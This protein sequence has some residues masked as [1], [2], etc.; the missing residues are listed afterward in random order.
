MKKTIILPLFFFLTSCVHET[1]NKNTPPPL[2]ATKIQYPC[3]TFY[4]SSTLVT[5][6]YSRKMVLSYKVQV[7][8]KKGFLDCEKL[9]KEDLNKVC[10]TGQY[11]GIDLQFVPLNMKNVM[12]YK[13][14]SCQALT[15]KRDSSGKLKFVS[16]NKM[17][18]RKQIN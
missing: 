16:E 6:E 12:A 4:R 17:R 13:N 11:S 1:I 18:L 7:K 5:G 3:E 2:K 14:G 15:D 10:E 9:V 8:N